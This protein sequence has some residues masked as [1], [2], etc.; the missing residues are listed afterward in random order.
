MNLYLTDSTGAD[1]AVLATRKAIRDILLSSSLLSDE[2]LQVTYLAPDLGTSSVID[3]GGGSLTPETNLDSSLSAPMVT[4]ISLGVVCVV[5]AFAAGFRYKNKYDRDEGKSTLGPTGSEI[6]AASSS[7]S[8]G[9]NSTPGFSAMMPST[10]RIGESH[11]M[12]AILEGDSDSSHNQ[13]EIMVSDS[14]YSEEDSRDT[15]LLQ[16]SGE[17]VLGA[18]RLDGFDPSDSYLYDD[19]QSEVPPPS[20][21]GGDSWEHD[22]EDFRWEPSPFKS[23]TPTKQYANKLVEGSP[24]RKKMGGFPPL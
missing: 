16:Y 2:I 23:K 22:G 17:H 8:G 13:S 24:V 6:T 14:G 19:S 7:L 10:Y 9:S 21:L 5:V 20:L 18:E 1:D 15:S 11:C 4:M 3:N 12:D